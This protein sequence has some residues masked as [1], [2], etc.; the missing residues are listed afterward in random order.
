MTTKCW[1]SYARVERVSA[2]LPP[3]RTLESRLKFAASGPFIVLV[4]ESIT[5]RPNSNPEI[6]YQPPSILSLRSAASTVAPENQAPTSTAAAKPPARRKL[7]FFTALSVVAGVASASVLG[8]TEKKAAPEIRSGSP[9]FKTGKNGQNLHWHQNALTV[10]LDD[11]LQHM[12]PRANEAVM[13]AFG[14]WAASDPRLPDLT[15]DTGSSSAIPAHD[16]K[17]TISYGRITAPGHERDLAITVTYAQEHSGEIVEADIVLNSMYPIG[18]LTPK[19]TAGDKSTAPSSSKAMKDET[20]DCQNRYDVQNVTTHEVG[21][22]FGLG[23][24][25][26][27][28]EAA[29][30]QTIDQCE[31][32]KRELSDTDVAAISTLYAE[33]EDPEEAAAGPRA[34]SL[35]GAAQGPGLAW[36]SAAFV[37]LALLRRRR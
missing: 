15:F 4:T 21:H 19:A 17:S 13:Q 35:G 12:G 10:Y 6:R 27:E 8:T 5:P 18:V 37:G 16:G 30:F 26:V 20:M 22:F 23:E 33:S 34:C 25:P 7:W 29:M 11:S 1:Q 28:P 3:S 2:R 9:G 14:R 24:D 36:F 32:H 31:T